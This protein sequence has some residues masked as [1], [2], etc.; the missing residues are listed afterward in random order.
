[1]R[2]GASSTN[3]G[4]QICT[5][6]I[7]QCG[8]Y[9]RISAELWAA[10]DRANDEYQQ[11]L[12]RY[13]DQALEYLAQLPKPAPSPFGAC[14]TCGQEAHFGYRDKESG[15]LVWFCAR[16]RLATWWTDARRS[17]KAERE[18][19]WTRKRDLD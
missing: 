8:G 9:G 19:C 14:A 1:L 10:W 5:Q 2:G 4:N 16:H 3:A 18:P 7:E 15:Q 6:L 13:L 12:R 17:Q 11:Q